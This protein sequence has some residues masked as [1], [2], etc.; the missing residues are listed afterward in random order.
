M[1]TLD[2]SSDLP[3][4]DSRLARASRALLLAEAVAPVL[5]CQVYIWLMPAERQRG[6]D[7]L[8]GLLL[9]A[10]AVWAIRQ[11]GPRGAA[12]FGVARSWSH[13]RAALP[14]AVFA[15]AA[16]GTLLVG[17]W[18]TERLRNE[19]DLWRALLGYPLWAV[20]QQGLF[21]GVLYPRL[22][23]ACGAGAAPGLLALLFAVAH[24]PN[25]L[26]MVG[27]GLMSLVFATVWEK[28]PSLPL[29]A[30]AH[31]VIGAVCDKGL[32]VSMRVGAHYFE[33]S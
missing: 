27:G 23:A 16:V 5:V 10:W 7:L 20:V 17:G 19:G 29:V 12:A 18:L 8:L 4:S 6:F 30:L 25:P 28:A 15:L 3:L 33:H 21:L 11:R 22:R 31:G 1:S 26:L 32:H 14:L 9:A 13:A 24:A 2:T